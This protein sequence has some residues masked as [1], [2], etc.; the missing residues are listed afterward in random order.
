MPVRP[1]SRPAVLIEPRRKI[2]S[3]APGKHACD[4]DV[5]QS[6]TREA[7]HRHGAS[8]SSSVSSLLRVDPIPP[9]NS[10]VVVIGSRDRSRYLRVGSATIRVED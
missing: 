3:I 1:A 8:V 5:A 4:C 7:R 9:L 2:T 10:V 6:M